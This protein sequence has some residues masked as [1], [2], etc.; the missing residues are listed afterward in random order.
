MEHETIIKEKWL[1]SRG[2]RTFEDVL[3]DEQGEYIL[4]GSPKGESK[5]YLPD[6]A[7]MIEDLT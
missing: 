3:V 6:T 4:M 5:F 7:K 1:N 2:G